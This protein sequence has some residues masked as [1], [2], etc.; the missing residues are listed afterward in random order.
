[1]GPVLIGDR[2][3]WSVAVT[4]NLLTEIVTPFTENLEIDEVCFVDLMHHL[5]AQGPDGFAVCDTTGEASTPTDDEQLRMIELAT[6]TVRPCAANA[7]AAAR[8][9][10]V[11]SGNRCGGMSSHYPLS[12]AVLIKLGGSVMPPCPDAGG[13]LN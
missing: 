9:I 1:M 7:N 3:G 4:R 13:A 6:V 12:S 11:P 10:S 5:A 2:S 8:P